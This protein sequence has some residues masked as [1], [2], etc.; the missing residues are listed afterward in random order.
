MKKNTPSKVVHLLKRVTAA[1]KKVKS[2]DRAQVLQKC[3]NE[4][5][6]RLE[7]PIG[8]AYFPAEDN[9]TRLD[10]SKLWFFDKPDQYKDF[11]DITETTAF[12]IGA[13]LPGRVLTT[14][15]PAWIPD[16]TKDTNSPRANRA[17]NIGVKA[18]FAFPVIAD[19]EVIAVL[20]FFHPL[21]IEPDEQILAVMEDIGK[22]VGKVIEDKV[23]EV[24]KNR[25][26]AQ[27]RESDLKEIQPEDVIEPEFLDFYTEHIEAIWKQVVKLN[28]NVYCLKRIEEFPFDL[29][30]HNPS[31]FWTCVVDSMFETSVMVINR[32]LIDKDNDGR[33]LTLEGLKDKIVCNLTDEKYKEQFKKVSEVLKDCQFGEN[34][35]H[36]E[37]RMKKLRNKYFAHF[38]RG[39][40]IKVSAEDIEERTVFLKEIYELTEYINSFFQ[41]LHF[42]HGYGPIYWDY[43]SEAEHPSDIEILLDTI[44]EKSDVMHMPEENPKFW[45]AYRR[46]IVNDSKIEIFN[47]YRE[48]F[49]LPPA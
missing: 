24:L 10:S 44:A 1:V 19:S 42:G 32:I 49:N 22:Q 8:H 37:K 9:P 41:L 14:K 47:K 39:F 12:D 48:K 31:P 29:F 11:R 46:E 21:A 35:N 26:E 5:C 28:S 33:N 23:I 30:K 25:F 16:V 13:G 2:P 43:R 6:T 4:V 27:L 20:E 17:E 3:I 38:D 18:A 15:K 40:N 45:E 7:W 34:N 36:I